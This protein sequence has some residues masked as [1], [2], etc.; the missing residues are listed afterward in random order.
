MIKGIYQSGKYVTV[1]G[2]SAPSVNVHFTNAAPQSSAA[3]G[4]AGQ[5]R[6][7]T[8]G[9]CLEIFDGNNWQPWYSSTASVGLTPDAEEIIDWAKNKMQQEQRL[10]ALMEQHPGL[11]ELHEKLEVMKIL[12]EKQEING[13]SST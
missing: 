13:T 3:H 4:V 8:I 1:A 11:K 9:Q 6:Y 7:S 10:Q 2:G 5:I 12:V